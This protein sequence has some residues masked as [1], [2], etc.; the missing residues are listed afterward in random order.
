MR[1]RALGLKDK[2]EEEEEGFP[3]QG[4]GGEL[5]SVGLGVVGSACMRRNEWNL[6]L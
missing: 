1:F 3:I 4:L 2:L 5:G 6:R